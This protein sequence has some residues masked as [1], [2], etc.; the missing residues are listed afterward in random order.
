MQSGVAAQVP[1]L[2]VAD[3]DAARRFYEIFGYTEIRAGGD[4]GSRWSYLRCGELTLLL[5]AVT[6]RLVTVELPLLVYLYVDD[7]T[8]TAERLTAAG[9]PVEKAGYPEHAPGGECRV[10]DPDGNV[11]AFGQRQA[12]PPQERDPQAGG[13]VRFSLIREAA[14]AV[15]RRGGAPARCQI[16]GPRGESCAEP[17]EV[18]LA[19]SWGDTA[20]GCMAHADETLLTARGAFLATEDGMGLGPFLRARQGQPDR[21]PTE[22]TPVP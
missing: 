15:G 17:A 3:A 22:E 18:K 14:E 12:V 9:H 11:V 7:L 4:G 19:D 1:V 10:T 6:P 8:A 2:Y 21:H 5:A 20:W 16:G 13:E